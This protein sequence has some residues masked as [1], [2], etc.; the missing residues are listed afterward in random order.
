MFPLTAWSE[1]ALWQVRRLGVR[2]ALAR[3]ARDLWHAARRAVFLRGEGYITCRTPDMD[4]APDPAVGVFVAGLADLGL[5]NGQFSPARMAVI[6]RRLRRGHVL[7]LAHVDSRVAGHTWLALKPT[8]CREIGRVLP[9][10]PHEAYGYDGFTFPEFRQR[11]V[12]RA[13]QAE[14]LAY[15]GRNDIHRIYGVVAI[16]NSNSRTAQRKIGL[17]PVMLAGY[18]RVLGF[19]HRWHRRLAGGENL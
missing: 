3:R 7:F 8:Y 16:D 2:G 15:A 5:L 13:L 18:V 14:T 9:L 19:S 11:G 10:R 4:F 17:P 6:R 12:F 1:D